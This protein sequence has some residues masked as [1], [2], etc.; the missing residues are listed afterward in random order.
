MSQANPADPARQPVTAVHWIFVALISVFWIVQGVGSLQVAYIHD[1]LNL[2][3]GASLA[4]EGRFAELHDVSVQLERERELGSVSAEVVPFVRPHFYAL[5]LAPLSLLSYKAAFWAWIL[6]Q[7]ALLVVCWVWGRRRFGP[8]SLIFSVL[9]FPTI[10]GIL[11]GQDCVILAV[12]AV[13]AYTQAERGRELRSGM[14]MSLALIKFHLLIL[15]PFAMLLRRRTKMMLGFAM[16][17]A[18]LA[19]LSP[20][21]GGIAGVESYIALLTNKDL[22]RLSPSP[23]RMTNIHAIF[24]SFGVDNLGLTIVGVALVVA[25]VMV[26]VGS[27]PLWRWMAAALAGSLLIVPHVYGYDGGIMLPFLLLTVFKSKDTYSRI[28]ATTFLTPL[29]FF[30]L[31]MGPPWTS[32]PAL[33]LL[34]YLAALA[35]ESYLDRKAIAMPAGSAA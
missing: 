19:L 29:P 28:I 30:A 7:T 18:G 11:N 34:S 35:R 13:V 22:E 9:Y 31:M 14:V 3:T 33:V 21:L 4:A 12:I 15:L 25:L 5:V 10:G 32:V 26:A 16:G 27:A 2:Y 8:D 24:A 23:E 20:L 17:A 1:F 6:L